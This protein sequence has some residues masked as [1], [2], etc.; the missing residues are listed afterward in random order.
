MARM[1][2]ELSLVLVGSS[3]LTA[4]YFLYPED[5]LEAKQKEQVAQQVAGNHHTTGTHRSG[6]IWIHTGAFRGGYSNGSVGSRPV[7]MGGNVSRGGFGS[8]GRGSVGG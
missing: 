8:I 5:D 2:R 7:A 1:T 6:F 3:I 4:G